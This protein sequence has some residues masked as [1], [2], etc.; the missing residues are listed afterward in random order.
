MWGKWRIGGRGLRGLWRG[1]TATGR[2][3]FGVDLGLTD[4]RVVV[5]KIS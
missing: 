4:M 5:R 2:A 1:Y 3:K